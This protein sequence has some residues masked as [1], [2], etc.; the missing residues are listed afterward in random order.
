MHLAAL[1][2]ASRPDLSTHPIVNRLLELKKGVSDL[3]ELDFAAGSVSDVDPLVG[4]SLGMFADGDLNLDTE[5]KKLAFMELL[6]KMR[7]ADGSGV[8]VMS[9]DE[10][11]D[12]D[13][14]EL[15]EDDLGD[16]D[17][18]WKE[19]GLEEDELADLLADAD[20][21]DPYP[22]AIK[23]IPT[24]QS[25][26]KAKANGAGDKKS[27]ASREEAE[28]KKKRVRKAKDG[29]S[30]ESAKPIATFAPLPEPAFYSS[31]SK[32]KSSRPISA[33][34]DTLGDA[35]ALLDADATDKERRTKSLRFHTSKIASTSARRA[36]ARAQRSG[37]DDDVPYRDRQK[38]RDAALRK[39]SA[40][41]QNGGEDLDPSGGVEWSESEKKRARE[42]RE[43]SP[44][45]DDRSAG[46]YYDLVKRRKT[47]K[48][49]EK[50]AAHEERRAEK[51]YVAFTAVLGLRDC[52]LTSSA[53]FEDETADGPRA[54]TRAIEKNRGLTPRRNKTGRNPRVKKRQAYEKAKQ[55]VGSQRA[56]Y[57]GGQAAIGGNYQGEK[58]G[59]STVVK[60]RKF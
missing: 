1:P 14:D 56:V 33:A 12:E 13:D 57:K 8:E 4:Q 49:A 55:K 20:G 2:P 16:F 5:E 32:N 43:D 47:E 7:E 23:A 38:A 54:L 41:S 10:E 53:S 37:G 18:S 58:T 19:A 28:G 17:D 6:A 34:D 35:T 50:E 52:P 48:Q 60:S 42:V 21:E 27:K 3:E 39:N 59:I 31:S 22:D 25:K 15:D 24:K 11:E 51:L 40:A 30:K 36:A 44:E 29:Q 46:E 45:V 26:S 9:D